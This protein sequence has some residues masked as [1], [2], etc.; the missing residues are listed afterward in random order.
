[1]KINWGTGIVIAFVCFMAFILYFVIKVQ[2]DHKYDNDLVVE[3]YYKHDAAFGSEMDKVQKAYDLNKR[4]TIKA[5]NEQVTIQFPESFDFKKINGKVSFY[6]PSN[7]KLDFDTPISLSSSSLL[8]PK[9]NLVG[10]LWDISVIWTYE[11]KEF[12][13]KESV[14]IK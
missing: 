3:D 12:I 4:V 10:G 14:Y 8:I 1:M 2:T 9:T 13:S 11:G 5:S 6:R 7:K